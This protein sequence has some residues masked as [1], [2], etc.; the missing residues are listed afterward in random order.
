MSRQYTIKKPELDTKFYDYQ[1]DYLESYIIWL[2]KEKYEKVPESYTE[3]KPII[4]NH[5]VELF[6]KKLLKQPFTDDDID[7]LAIYYYQIC[8]DVIAKAIRSKEAAEYKFLKFK[9]KDI[10]HRK[11][12]NKIPLTLEDLIK[13]IPEMQQ[14]S[15]EDINE[16]YETYRDTRIFYK[17]PMIKTPRDKSSKPKIQSKPVEL[18]KPR[19]STPKVKQPKSKILT[20]NIQNDI[21]KNVIENINGTGFKSPNKVLTIINNK[22]PDNRINI[23]DVKQHLKL[24]IDSFPLKDN[25]KKYS[26][27]VVAPIGTY[28]MDLMFVSGFVYLIAINVNTRKAYAAS[29]TNYSNDDE[30]NRIIIDKTGEKSVKNILDALIHLISYTDFKPRIIRGDGEKSFNSKYLQQWFKN[31]HITFIPVRRLSLNNTS[32]FDVDSNDGKRNDPQ[33]GSLSIID[34]FIRTI[35]DMAYNM[36]IKHII[37][38]EMKILVDNYNMAPHKH[39]SK[40][41]GEPTSPNDMD[42]DRE[43]YIIRKICQENYNIRDQAWYHLPSGMSVD[44]YNEKDSMFKRRS[45]KRYGNYRIVD[46]K[47]GLYNVRDGDNDN[48]WVPRYMLNPCIR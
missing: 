22:F 18:P 41:L 12:L 19:K 16:L 27:H 38:D 36:K 46:Y 43:K 6:S 35:R 44:V 37:P 33:H 1:Y 30:A 14:L 42:E 23:S 7:K 39:L 9:V 10:I 4:E 3:F 20:I 5:G 48:I 24:P 28:I 2:F 11:A 45:K 26:L 21:P 15:K 8:R 47:G 40:Y 32:Y 31:E 13:K 29:T 34:R 25:K 17:L